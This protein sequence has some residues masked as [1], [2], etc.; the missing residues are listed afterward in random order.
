MMRST[1]SLRLALV[2]IL[3]LLAS[4]LLASA[5]RAQECAADCTLS[6]RG[7]MRE[8]TSAMRGCTAQCREGDDIGACVR[9]CVP[10]FVDAKETCRKDLTACLDGCGARTPAPPPAG[11]RN[12]CGVAL[13][14]C[15]RD[16]QVSG[17]QC[18]RGCAEGADRGACVS[19][20]T[21]VTRDG[22]ARCRAGLRTCLGHCAGPGVS[23]TSLGG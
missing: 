6:R 1:R 18:I 7:C 3:A 23:P 12:G 16:V 17:R 11:C 13:T 20:C 19:A 8:A 2:A 14:G 4:G 22:A 9:G 5:A 10:A 15:A 21:A